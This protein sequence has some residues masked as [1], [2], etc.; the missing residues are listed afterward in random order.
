MSL[1]EA[2]ML[3]FLLILS[4]LVFFTVLGV[5]SYL[6][7]CVM[8]IGLQRVN[9]SRGHGQRQAC[10]GHS[11]LQHPCQRMWA[12]PMLCL[13]CLGILGAGSRSEVCCAHT[14]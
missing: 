12:C 8:G 1:F 9:A 10:A 6:G 4:G 11:A 14:C 13:G 3:H 5:Y 2:A 7:H